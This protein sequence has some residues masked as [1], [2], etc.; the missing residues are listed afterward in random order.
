[1]DPRTE[2]QLMNDYKKLWTDLPCVGYYSADFCD[3]YKYPSVY[4]LYQ[5]LAADEF[6]RLAYYNQHTPEEIEKWENRNTFFHKCYCYI[7][8]Q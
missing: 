7:Q 6:I 8:A 3:F 1:M 4:C 2:E 5:C